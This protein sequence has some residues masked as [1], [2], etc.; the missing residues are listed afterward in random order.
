MLDRAAKH[1]DVD[2]ASVQF[3][4]QDET[5]RRDTTVA[6]KGISINDVTHE[7]GERGVVQNVTIVLIGCVTCTV[8][9]GEGV[10]NCGKT[11]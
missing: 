5:L 3:V 1:V 10:H 2:A 6:A 4:L 8:T 7:R 9:W 11:V